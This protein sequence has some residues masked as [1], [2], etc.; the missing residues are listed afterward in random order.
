MT[1]GGETDRQTRRYSNVT[2]IRAK[3]V[4]KFG[5]KMKGLVHF[6]SITNV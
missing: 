3:G 4:D 2:D 6:C 1:K 5:N